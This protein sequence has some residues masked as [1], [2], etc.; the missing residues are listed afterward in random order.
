MAD[1]TVTQA[2]DSA[3]KAY[4]AAAES[5][6]VRLAAPVQD[7]PGPVEFPSSVKRG[8]K[9]RSA[10]APETGETPA[11]DAPAVN[12]S[13]AVEGAVAE[14]A[15]RPAAA[16]AARKKVVRKPARPSAKPVKAPVKKRVISKTKTAPASTAKKK[17]VTPS[18]PTISQLKDKIMAA[19]KTTDFTESFKDV[20]ADA[21]E[22]AKAAFEKSNAA[23]GEMNDFAKGNAEALVEAGKILAAGL[24]D[25]GTACVADGRSAFETLTADVKELAAARTPADFFKLQSEFVRRN[26]DSAVAY[27]SKNSEALL[28]LANEAFAPISGRVSLAVE[29][30]KKAA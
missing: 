19:T 10:A 12:A 21:Q 26:F 17:T 9:A 5:E 14:A 18:F 24:Q 8:R 2:E 11:V 28:K 13:S 22:K 27:G 16:K 23:F 30:V 7:E 20:I 1:A 6:T 4:A 3:E 29:I 25:L 15:A